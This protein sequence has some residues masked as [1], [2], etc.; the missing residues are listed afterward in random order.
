MRVETKLQFEGSSRKDEVDRLR[1]R[2]QISLFIERERARKAR[3]ERREAE[4]RVRHLNLD[5]VLRVVLLVF[6]VGIGIGVIVGSVGNPQLLELS[7]LASSAWAAIAASLI[8]IL[9]P[10]QKMQ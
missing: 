6:A 10:K 2:S 7:L 3:V 5:L 9:R 4:A 8:R 1:T